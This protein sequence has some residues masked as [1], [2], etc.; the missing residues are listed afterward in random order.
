MPT[1]IKW[2]QDKEKIYLTFHFGKSIGIKSIK[3]M[4]YSFDETGAFVFEINEDKFC[5]SIL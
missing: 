2:G 4:T 3:E 1:T 5:L